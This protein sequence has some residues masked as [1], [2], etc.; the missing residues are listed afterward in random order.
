MEGTFNVSSDLFVLL[1]AIPLIAKL[2]L[3]IQQ[4]ASLVTVFGMGF[5]VIVAAILT[6]VFSLDQNLVSYSYLNWY[7]R[8]AS[9][10]V[11]VVNVP[12]L[13]ALF[14]DTFP[15]IRTWGYKSSML[16]TGLSNIPNNNWQSLPRSKNELRMM[17]REER[18]FED[19]L[20]SHFPT[21]NHEQI[22]PR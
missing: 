4:K 17:S 12:A 18:A 6:K 7:F 1:V 22:L 20:E 16:S 10:S 3:P 19:E 11:F 15:A 13:Y 21:N 14:R 5:F 2:H 9:V 8:E